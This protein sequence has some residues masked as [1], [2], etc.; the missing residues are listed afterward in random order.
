MIVYMKFVSP[1]LKGLPRSDTLFGGICWGIRWV[2]GEKALTDLLERFD[3][4]KGDPPFTLSSAFPY[5]EEEGARL[6][7]LPRPILPP[8]L[9]EADDLK[10]LRG[11]K[12]FKKVRYLDR[13][14]FNDLINGRATLKILY[15][16]F[17]DGQ[18]AR[19]DV[20]LFETP[21]NAINR[22]SGSVDEGRLFFSSEVSVKRG[23]LFFLVRCQDGEVA[24]QVRGAV[25]FL[26]DRGIGGDASVGRGAFDPEFSD[27]E[28][29]EEPEEGDRCMTLSLVHPTSNDLDF[30][31]NRQD[32]LSYELVRRKGHVESMFMNVPRVWKETLLMFKEGSVFPVQ[33]D[34]SIRGCAPVVHRD[35][36]PV[37]QNGYAY[38]VRIVT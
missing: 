11:F 17:A 14:D 35:A 25:R 2:F 27:E 36:F 12:K 23:G 1:F 6:H 16:R 9:E 7:F 21:G 10:T 18:M 22:L 32:R 37:R 29:I 15:E 34:R 20:H 3:N 30:L 13:S 26:G 31:S 24:E 5:V 38:A 4:D 8:A 19:P 33:G 28:V